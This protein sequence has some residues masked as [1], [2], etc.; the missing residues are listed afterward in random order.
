VTRN[1]FSSSSFSL[2]FPIDFSLS[3]LLKPMIRLVISFINNWKGAPAAATHLAAMSLGCC[4]FRSLE[5]KLR[6]PC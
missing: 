2:F 3:R 1:F 4:L 5:R 6:L